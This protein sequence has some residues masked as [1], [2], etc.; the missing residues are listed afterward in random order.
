MIK[1]TDIE[2][3]KTAIYCSVHGEW[4][5]PDICYQK[6]N[7]KN[8]TNCAVKVTKDDENRSN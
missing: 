3:W 7:Y 1:G 4:C 6:C 2:V 5:F 8:S